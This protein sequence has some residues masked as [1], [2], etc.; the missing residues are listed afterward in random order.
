MI[1]LFFF[2]MIWEACYMSVFTLE[3]SLGFLLTICACMLFVVYRL[4]FIKTFQ[5]KK[6]VRRDVFV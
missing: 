2:L 5:N 4:H 6:T 3:S 1:I